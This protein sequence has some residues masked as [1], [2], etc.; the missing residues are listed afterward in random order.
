ME[1]KWTVLLG[2]KIEF[3][4]VGIG[5]TNKICTQWSADATNVLRVYFNW[6]LFLWS[7]YRA[8][9][10]VWRRAVRA[11]RAASGGARCS[12]AWWEPL[13]AELLLSYVLLLFLRRLNL[14]RLLCS[15]TDMFSFVRRKKATLLI[16]QGKTFCMSANI[17]VVSSTAYSVR[18]INWVEC[19]GG[20]DWNTLGIGNNPPSIPK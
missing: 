5:L 3:S 7:V 20:P 1:V 9:E 6:R 10:R 17:E 19:V 16:K 2:V 18:N 4:R 14:I 15:F 11:R 8:L 12:S 13:R